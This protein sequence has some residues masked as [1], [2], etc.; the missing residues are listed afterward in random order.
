MSGATSGISDPVTRLVDL[1]YHEPDMFATAE[2]FEK[3][4]HDDIAALT[5]DELDAERI[6]A[7]IRWAVLVHRRAAPSEWLVERLGRL[8]RAADRLRKRV[9]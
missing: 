1:V 8:D 7:R 3:V 5:L 6:L 4:H 9:R 2:E